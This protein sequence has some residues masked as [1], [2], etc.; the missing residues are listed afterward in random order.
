MLKFK[1]FKF[2]L[3]FSLNSWLCHNFFFVK[4][5]WCV[6]HWKT[7]PPWP[8][9]FD[10][11]A[12][13]HQAREAY[14]NIC[15]FLLKIKCTS[16]FANAPPSKTLQDLAYRSLYCLALKMQLHVE[17]LTIEVF[18]EI[19]IQQLCVID[20]LCW[21]KLVCFKLVNM[22]TLVYFLDEGTRLQWAKEAY[23]IF[24]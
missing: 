4:I 15:L 18:V 17:V 10:E 12:R 24:C 9:L 22:S 13:L 20:F 21:N 23:L 6:S 5:S 7:F 19:F 1:E 14:L 16:L 2:L 11:D 8:I 3:T